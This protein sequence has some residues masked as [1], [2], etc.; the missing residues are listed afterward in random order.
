MDFF[1]LILISIFAFSN[2]SLA[3][4]KEKNAIL[5][6]FITV[7]LFIV[8]CMAGMM[9]VLLTFCRNL[10]DLNRM[11]TMTDKVARDA[12][13]QQVA[14]SLQ[15]DFISNPLHSITVLLFGVGG[16]LLARYILESTPDK[17]K[18]E[19]HWMDRMGEQEQQ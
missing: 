9:F 10:V 7:A 12:Y 1:G 18:P 3:R 19:V 4:V 17:K 5:W 14:V 6:A 13:S 15:Q 2:A 8:G 16:F 11:A